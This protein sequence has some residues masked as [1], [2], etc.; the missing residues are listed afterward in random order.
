[1]LLP[2]LSAFAYRRTFLLLFAVSA[3]NVFVLAATNTMFGADFPLSED[4][5]P[6]FWR[7]KVSF[8]PLLAR[9]GVHGALP[10]FAL[11]VTYAIAL[12]W[13]FR[14][15]L[16]SRRRSPEGVRSC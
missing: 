4:A 13:L 11:A 15:V 3:A 10:G 14:S 2:D 6:D 16:M 7:G 9:N 8:N 1:M 5:Y 12:G